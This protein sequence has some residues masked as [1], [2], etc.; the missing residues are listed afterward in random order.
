[1][2]RASQRAVVLLNLMEHSAHQILMKRW[3]LL[4]QEPRF[5]M[6]I[7]SISMCAFQ[8]VDGASELSDHSSQISIVWQHSERRNTHGKT[9]SPIAKV[10]SDK[11]LRPI[12][13]P[14]RFSSSLAFKMRVL[15][16]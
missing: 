3:R 11:G 1:M 5:K 4:L 6:S 9:V 13:Q 8:L 7:E 15:P 12:K 2:R 16:K 10:V 14:R